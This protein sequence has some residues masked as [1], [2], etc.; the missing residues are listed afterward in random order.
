MHFVVD[1]DKFQRL[2]QSLIPFPPRV[3]QKDSDPHSLQFRLS[4]PPSFSCLDTLKAAPEPPTVQNSH[5]TPCPHLLRLRIATGAGPAA[6]CLDHILDFGAVFHWFPVPWGLKQEAKCNAASSDCLTTDRIAS[7][8]FKCHA[9]ELQ[10]L[11]VPHTPCIS[12][13]LWKSLLLGVYGDCVGIVT[14]SSAV[15]SAGKCK[16]GIVKLAAR[17]LGPDSY[18]HIVGPSRFPLAY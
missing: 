15:R 4:L 18:Q 5:A 17:R 7:P 8:W 3:P 11:R 16:H 2:T 6:C 14:C 9:R 12:K 1:T 13:R 10:Y